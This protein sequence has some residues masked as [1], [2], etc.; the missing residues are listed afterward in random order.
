MDRKLPHV[1]GHEVA[2]IV[3]A[4]DA[5]GIPAMSRVYVHHHAPCMQCGACQAGHHV[6]CQTWKST[7]LQPGGMAEIFAVSPELLA[8]THVVNGLRAEEAALAEPLACVMKGIRRS[9]WQQGDRAAV[10]GLGFMGLLH[11]FALSYLGASRREVVAYD[12]NESRRIHA[13]G[14]GF[15]ARPIEE[16]APADVA[17]VCPGFQS[18]LDLGVSLVTAGGTVL[19]F[20]PFSSD[21]VPTVDINRLYF[22]DASL[23]TSYSAGPPDSLQA[24]QLLYSG[25]LKAEQVVS[26]FITLDELP[27]AYQRMKS[28]EILKP[29]VLFAG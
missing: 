2:G 23:V 5:P 25:Q 29:M 7:K 21:V 26:D 3:I 22:L 10:V 8:D 17:F 16:A 20:S 18:A 1:L 4:S 14:L 6:H 24:L 9:G 27:E 15:E 12:L 11:L 13:L 19:L 28:S